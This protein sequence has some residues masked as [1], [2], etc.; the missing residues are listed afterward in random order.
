MPTTAGESH[1]PYNK[2]S[3]WPAVNGGGKGGGVTLGVNGTTS[4]LA[5]IQ[6]GYETGQRQ[7]GYFVSESGATTMSS[8][9]SMSATLSKKN[10][11]LHTKPFYERN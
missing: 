2:A 1:G 8:F 5:K 6:P 10:W 9:E 3:E 7:P 11:G 4:P